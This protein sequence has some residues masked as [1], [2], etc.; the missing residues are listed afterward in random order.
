MVGAMKLRTLAL[1]ASIFATVAACGG[2]PD[3]NSAS[4]AAKTVDS[5]PLALLPGTPIVVAVVDAKAFFGSAAVGQ[6]AGALVQQYLPIGP[7]VFVASRDL[8]RVTC[9]AYSMQGADVACVLTGTF[10]EAKIKQAAFVRAQPVQGRPGL[11]VAS[12]YAGKD[13]FTQ[14]NVG[15]SVLSARTAVAGTEAGIRRV[16]DRVH[17]GRF[18]RTVLPWMIQTLETQGSAAAVAADFASQPAAQ[19]GIREVPGSAGIRAFRAVASFKEP[20]FNVAASGTYADAPSANAAADKVRQNAQLLPFLALF[21]VTV[22]QFDVKTEQSDVQITF[23]TD[24]ASLRKLLLGAAQAAPPP[25][26]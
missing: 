22:K 11:L 3:A 4:N 1:A 25:A 19:V 24:D 15:F 5:D 8:E 23:A 7:D 12:Q 2:K 14:Q 6:Q 21:G 20:G 16:L 9:G 18:E 13:V 10:D 26:R 17:E